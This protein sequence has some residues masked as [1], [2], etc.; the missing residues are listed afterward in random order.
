MKQIT[1]KH[2]EDLTF[3]WDPTSFGGKGYWYVLGK[4][5]G[6]G[7]AASKKEA[8]AL[9]KP[10]EPTTEKETEQQPSKTYKEEIEPTVGED[11]DDEERTP[12]SAKSI[13]RGK[14]REAERIK[15]TKLSELITNNLIEGKGAIGSITGAIGTKAKA[16]GT[17]LKKMFDLKERM[18]PLNIAKF[19][20]G[21]SSMGPALVGRMLG[22]S[23]EDIEHYSGRRAK[24][25]KGS[26]SLIRSAF[27]GK[28][29]TPVD[30]NGNAAAD[31]AQKLVNLFSKY[32][33]DKK[34]E[35]QVKR[36]FEEEKNSEENR[37]HQEILNI[38]TGSRL[39]AQKVGS[40]K[41]QAT[42]L[43][44]DVLGVVG[45]AQTLLNVL[46]FFTGPLGLTI[47]G[48]TA[49]YM[50]VNWIKDNMANGRALTPD[51][52]KN[53]LETGSEKDIA[54]FGGR[55]ALMQTYQE[56]RGRAEDILARYNKEGI[57][58]EEKAA[59][60]KEALKYGGIDKLKQTVAEP[61][62]T[63]QVGENTYIKTM[64]EKTT[65]REQYA[66]KGSARK[67]KLEFWDKN[68]GPYYDADS[69]VRKDLMNKQDSKPATV[70]ATTTPASPTSSAA[71][72]LP[73][74]DSGQKI[75]TAML[76]Q[77]ELTGAGAP[78]DAP[79]V[80]QNNTSV[81]IPGQNTTG[82]VGNNPVRNM[83]ESLEKVQMGSLRTV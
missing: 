62:P 2:Q 13:K 33:E 9:G 68:F 64:A 16:R 50:F 29:I 43:L 49:A 27:S 3:V 38:L 35:M 8:Q 48:F 24:G 60:E 15:G 6:Y 75:E 5:N 59:I 63:G 19:L 30:S 74:P 78:A 69:G 51:E 67:S 81:T 56:G 66:G 57:T 70:P 58:K 61:A 65:P 42:S 4:N 28:K 83:D 46:K 55:V 44:D 82:V 20:T 52:A 23:Q 32:F 80:V 47:L 21:G 40:P 1:K 45:S 10:N 14:Y 37:R 77:S 17:R 25:S 71:P 76:Q 26:A 7:R 22:S 41:A 73:T 39:T 31:A 72:I 34:R 79:A 54:F 36:S 53:M 18:N 11:G 12:P